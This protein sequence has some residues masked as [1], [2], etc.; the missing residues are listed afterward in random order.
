[1]ALRV[2]RAFRA[3]GNV[4]GFLLACLV[5]LAVIEGIARL[6][7][8]A[9]FRPDPDLVAERRHTRY[10]PELGWSNVPGKHVADLYGPGR[11]LT[12]NSQGF[13]AERVYASRA[14]KGRVRA[15]C[16]GDSFTLGFGVGD[17]DTWCARLERLEPRFE[18]VNMGQGGYGVDQ[19][20]LWYRRD[21]AALQPDVVLF[22]FIQED[23]L[24]MRYGTFLGYGRPLLRPAADGGLEVL[25]V[26]VPRS[27][28]RGLW[29]AQLS[30]R[31]DLLRVVQLARPA[32]RTW[33]G[34]D[35]RRLSREELIRIGGRIFEE[36]QRRT[37]EQGAE[38]VL[39]Y[40]PRSWERGGLKSRWRSP[41]ADEAR[42]RGI[43]FVDIAEELDTLSARDVAG[44]YIPTGSVDFPG[45]AGHFN[46]AGNAWVAESLLARLRDLPGPA[47]VLAAA[48]RR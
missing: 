16:L 26:P 22:G 19:A 11:H 9:P 36:L 45:A 25:N 34:D 20:Y 29:L 6:V 14:P 10:D 41:L 15:V 38:L 18:T 28:D 44:L 42:R 7:S 31:L 33:T 12:I 46:E 37:A 13:R 23:F 1:M 27:G 35:E 32:L 2:S 3:A 8:V 17:A 39:L 40:L 30:R 43:A 48:D 21:G 24:R 47:A 4:L 5:V